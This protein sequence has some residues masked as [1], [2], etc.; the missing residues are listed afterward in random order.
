MNC[1]LIN[2]T[3]SLLQFSAG[4]KITV[5]PRKKLL[6]NKE[7]ALAKSEIHSFLY[8]LIEKLAQFLSSLFQKVYNNNNT[9]VSQLQTK[10]KMEAIT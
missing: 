1:S 7:E 2:L 10:L 9:L 3:L 8:N 5:A 6:K 4:M